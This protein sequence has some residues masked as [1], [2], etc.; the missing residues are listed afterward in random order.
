M[1]YHANLA[2]HLVHTSDTTARRLSPV[3]RTISW[4]QFALGG[5]CCALAIWVAA[6]LWSIT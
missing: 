6:F 2:A 4:G 3:E 1:S 5:V